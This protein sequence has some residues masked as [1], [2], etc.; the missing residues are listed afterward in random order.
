MLD[1]KGKIGEK[2]KKKRNLQMLKED[3]EKSDVLRLKRKWKPGKAISCSVCAIQW[4]VDQH[5]ESL[6]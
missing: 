2:D 3:N 6:H 1:M 4:L 5:S